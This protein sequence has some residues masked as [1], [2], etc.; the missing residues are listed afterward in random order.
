ML[1][2]KLNLKCVFPEADI[3]IQCTLTVGKKGR[4][5]IADFEGVQYGG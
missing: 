3:L 4:G 1:A 5:S 2:N